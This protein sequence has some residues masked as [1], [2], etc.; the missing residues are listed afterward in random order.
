MKK[1]QSLFSKKDTRDVLD[2]NANI[3]EQ[4]KFAREHRTLS[5]NG[6]DKYAYYYTSILSKCKDAF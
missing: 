4:E 6:S 1:V 5:E 2:Q 3:F